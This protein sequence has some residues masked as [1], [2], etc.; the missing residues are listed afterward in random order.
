M[1]VNIPSKDI[2]SFQVL[3]EQIT[4]SNIKKVIF[5][6]SISV[7][8]S[9][10]CTIKEEDTHCYDKNNNLLEIENLFLQLKNVKSTILRL[11]GLIGYDRNLV[12]LFQ[13]REVKNSNSYV[14][15][16]HRDDCILIIKNIIEKDIF[17]DILN[18]V[19]SSHPTKEEFYR[20]CAK[21]SNL[22]TPKFDRKKID[23][24]IIDNTKLKKCLSYSF[25]YDDL[26]D[27][28]Y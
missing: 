22:D 11:G 2:D 24:K 13:K 27:I 28:K 1:I 9:C 26:F 23:Y 12:K 21:V 17:V 6:S 19:S 8:N 5:T 18:C 25:K 14:N 4:T 7:Y 15:M 3:C 20:Y 10:N 16:I